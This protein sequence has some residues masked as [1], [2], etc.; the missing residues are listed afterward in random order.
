MFNYFQQD[1]TTLKPVDPQEVGDSHH[2]MQL[3]V[4]LALMKNMSTEQLA[5]DWYCPSLHKKT[6]VFEKRTCNICGHYMASKLR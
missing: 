4:R 3:F 5:F 6:E 2:F 1:A